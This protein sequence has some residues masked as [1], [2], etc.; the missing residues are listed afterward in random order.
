[1]A[2]PQMITTHL[3]HLDDNDLVDDWE[4]ANEGVDVDDAGDE[5]PRYDD[6]FE[7]GDDISEGGAAGDG[8]E[9]DLESIHG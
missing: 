8:V 6:Q 1:M 7:G 5:T 9:A 3:T 4:N 2:A